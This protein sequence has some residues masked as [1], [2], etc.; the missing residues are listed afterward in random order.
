MA[1]T[2]GTAA[3]NVVVDADQMQ[4]GLSTARRSVADLS[5]QAQAE[6]N[7]LSTTQ[8]RAAESALNYANNIGKSRAEIRA[9]NVEQRVGGQLGRELAA[10]IRSAANAQDQMASSSARAAAGLGSAAMSAKQL[11]FATRQLPMQFTDIAVGLATGQAPMM[12]LLQQGGQLKDMFGG[13]GQ[14]AR[15]MGGYIM[16]LVNPVTVLAAAAGSLAVAWQ[17]N[18]DRMGS[19]QKAL[20]LTGSHAGLTA[21]ELSDLADE[22]DAMSGVTTGSATKALAAVAETGRFT[23]EQIGIVAKAAE[24]W[25][26]ATGTAID[27]TIARFV[28]LGDEPVEALLKL[29]ETEHFL[30]ETQIA[31]I[32]QLEREGEEQAAATE[33]M[34][35]YA[36]VV[37]T[38]SAQVVENLRGI[39][40]LWQ[41]I[42]QDTLDAGDA[43][44]GFVG[45]A[46]TAFSGLNTILQGY[47]TTLP[48]VTQLL[49][50]TPFG[51]FLTDPAGPSGEGAAPA[52][53]PYVAPDFSGVRTRF[54]S[55]AND[56]PERESR[57]RTAALTDEEKAAQALARSYESM[58]NQLHRQIELFGDTSNAARI[59]YE[60]QYG[61]LQGI[62]A[63][64]QE[65]LREAAAW[66]DWQKEMAEVDSIIADISGQRMQEMAKSAGE[67][68]GQIS[69]FAKEAGRNMQ[70]ALADFLFDPF[71]DGLD[72][73][74]ENFSKML[75]RLMAEY[76]ASEIFKAMGNWGN[77]NTGSF[78][79]NLASSMFGGKGHAEGGY[80]GPGGKYEPAGIVH[81]G[82]VVWSQKDVARAGGVAAVEAMRVG[83]LRGYANGGIV[84]M[85][86]RTVTGGAH[87][88]VNNYGSA[89]VEPREQV[90]NMPDGTQLRRFIIDVFSED[91][92][93]GGQSAA[94]VK[95]RLG[96]RDA[97]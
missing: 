40:G 91:F 15:A 48:R 21:D 45:D 79:G 86:A 74:V 55:S 76:A 57:T 20:I 25:R 67:S 78:W 5:T 9:F 6:F 2:I 77:A 63:A 33:A 52:G 31:R 83:G 88:E 82:E 14:A 84:G 26:V 13:V 92:A 28:E 95:N 36:D 58:N 68:F 43:V 24:Q 66:A 71:K 75:Q 56:K 93:N 97:V 80:T 17:A 34:R 35:L 38:R 18:E 65:V 87:I 81:R 32:R 50:T 7:K 73:M 27:E 4:A 41:G 16:G 61:A 37:D 12:V 3:I 44:I 8:K 94:V 70:D 42:K 19:L 1:E 60:I 62:S 96:L 90:Q 69:E 85:Q 51:R 89:R 72:G 46:E 54:S 30:T 47:L 49:R 23:G 39:R 11:Q 29:N 10:Q 59:N 22:M 53:D 64:Q